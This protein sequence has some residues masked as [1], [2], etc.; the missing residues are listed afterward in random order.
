VARLHH[1]PTAAAGH[2]LEALG[3]LPGQPL[4]ELEPVRVDVDEPRD[5]AE[6]DH[7]AARARRPTWATPKKGRRWCSQR[8]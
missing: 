4:L 2:L 1:D 3:D 6:T 8:L 5:L 7:P